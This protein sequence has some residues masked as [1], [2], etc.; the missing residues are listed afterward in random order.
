MYWLKRCWRGH[1]RIAVVFIFHLA[2]LE[3]LGETD[4]VM[5]GEQEAGIFA[6]EPFADCLHFGRFGVLFGDQVVEAEN[7]QGVGIGEDAFI[8]DEFV[9]GL[10]DALI[11]GDGLAGGFAGELLKGEGGAVKEF[12][13]SG[14]ALEE[15]GGDPLGRFVGGPGDAPD[16]G[17]G[18]KAI[19][20]FGGVA[21]G[22]PG[23][24]PGP[25]DAQ[26]SFAA[27]VF[28]RDVVLVIGSSD[29]EDRAHVRF[30][31]TYWCCRGWPGSAWPSGGEK[32]CKRLRGRW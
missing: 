6:F 17:H 29:L 16:L 5:R 28:A 31:F 12:E 4:V 26:A 9:T 7:Q 18:G 1:Q 21:V 20:H 11:D 2:L 19:V 22:F 3:V 24:A 23:I 15:L 8:N 25:I 30:P 32:R 14:D 10:V 27:D 13:G